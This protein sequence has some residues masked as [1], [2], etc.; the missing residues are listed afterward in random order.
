[1]HILI[2]GGSGFLGQALAHHLHQAGHSLTLHSRT[3]ERHQHKASV[4]ARWVQQFDEIETPIDAVVNLTGANLF[5]LPWS[6][7]RKKTL[8][9]SRI[10]TTSALVNWMRE[11]PQKPKVFLSGSAIGFYGDCGEEICTEGHSGG[12]D[13]AAQLVQAWET[14][15]QPAQDLGIRTVFLRTG[16][17]LGAGG[18]LPP[19]KLLF[20]LGLGGSLGR[21]TF[22]F[23]WIHI[24]DWV[25]AV[26]H[27]LTDDRASGP[28]N[29]TAPEPTRYRD[30]AA[31]LG[32]VLKRPVWLSP[33]IWALKPVLGQRTGLITAS[34]RAEPQA[35]NDLGYAWQFP[36]IRAAL[37]DLG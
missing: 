27:L 20:Q 36:N 12:S 13:W 17:V 8:W 7:G 37:T 14:Q 5:T 31:T 9:H 32:S 23:S 21:G 30:F 18:L 2:T 35:L 15:A 33:P 34:T 10:D 16:P 3:P 26:T 6:A 24:A 11:Q 1:M 22:W 19:Q 28:I 29:L 4:P 25:G